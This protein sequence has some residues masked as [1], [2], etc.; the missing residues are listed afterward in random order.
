M[1]KDI[2]KENGDAYRKNSSPTNFY[3]AIKVT[4]LLKG[5]CT[6]MWF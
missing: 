5:V 4:D 1:A 6:V 3:K 2:F